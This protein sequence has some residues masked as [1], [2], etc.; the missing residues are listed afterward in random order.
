[1]YLRP[2]NSSMLDIYPRRWRAAVPGDLLDRHLKDEKMSRD[3]PLDDYSLSTNR[4]ILNPS[5]QILL[6]ILG[7][8]NVISAAVSFRNLDSSALQAKSVQLGTSKEPHF[9]SLF[10]KDQEQIRLTN[11]SEGLY[12][13]KN[14]ICIDRA[15]KM[16]DDSADTLFAVL[17]NGSEISAVQL[18]SSRHWYRT[19]A[20]HIRRN[21][22]TQST[23]HSTLRPPWQTLVDTIAG[24]LILGLALLV[25]AG[26][27]AWDQPHLAKFFFHLLVSLLSLTKF[28]SAAAYISDGCEQ[29][30]LFTSAVIARA[31]SRFVP[32]GIALAGLWLGCIVA[33]DCLLLGNCAHLLTSPPITALGIGALSSILLL[34]HWHARRRAVRSAEADRVLYDAAWERL[35]REEPDA[36][37]LIV[38]VIAGR[39]NAL[40]AAPPARQLARSH[41]G[42][43][44]AGGSVLLRTVSGLLGA[45]KERAAD[46]TTVRTEGG[47]LIPVSSLDQLYAQVRD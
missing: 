28:L 18:L 17:D 47:Q 21:F 19:A 13:F 15:T 9:L 4:S 40:L 22:L 31:E 16:P 20:L 5:W 23:A 43:S 8:W 10:Y 2:K 38:A 32:A 36:V 12:E 34:I 41:T 39:R 26:C 45:E 11:V 6:L 3:I 1:M 29:D 30:W 44:L 27:G 46:E 35:R 42:P 14:S 24:D 25:T 37:G 33:H 7:T